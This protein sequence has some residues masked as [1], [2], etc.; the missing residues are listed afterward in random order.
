MPIVQYFL[1]PDMPQIELQNQ[2]HTSSRDRP[3]ASSTDY[4]GLAAD[5]HSQGLFLLPLDLLVASVSKHGCSLLSF[6]P[7]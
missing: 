4:Y 6:R 5:A 2:T 1:P 7:A 3:Y